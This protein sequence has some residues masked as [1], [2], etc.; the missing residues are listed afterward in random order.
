MPQRLN[1]RRG[2]QPGRKADEAW[3]T[4]AFHLAECSSLYR[5]A[6]NPRVACILVKHNRVVAQAVHERF[7]GLHAEALALAKAKTAARGATA[8]ITLEP[9]CHT[10]K[11]TPPCV[12]ALKHAGIRRVVVACRDENPRVLGRGI[13]ELKKAGIRVTQN[14]LQ[15]RARNL[16]RFFFHWIK[17]ARPFV[18]LKMAISIDGK[19]TSSRR[20]LSNPTALEDVQRIRAQHDAILVG[21]NTIRTDD[22]RLTVRKYGKDTSSQPLRV[23]L[24]SKLALNPHFRVFHNGPVLVACTNAASKKRKEAFMN[25]GIARWISPISEKGRVPFHELFAELGR[26]GIRSVLVEGGASVATNLLEEKR[27]NEAYFNVTPGLSG[28]RAV[29]LYTGRPM[30]LRNAQVTVLGDNAVF[31]VRFR[32]PR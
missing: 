22:P 27:V 25:A 6:P 16:Y 17:T 26:R 10:D 7:G 1:A 18:T 14:V 32:R 19:I 15:E 31:H 20:W 28:P 13:R 30:H 23:I 4:R 5:T 11:K 21:Q 3:M 9:C 29:S 8:Y 24:D 2:K 12:Q